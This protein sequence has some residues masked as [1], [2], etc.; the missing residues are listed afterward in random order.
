V[1]N[2][3]AGAHPTRCSTHV[4]SAMAV[5]LQALRVEKSGRSKLWEVRKR[6]IAN[7]ARRRHKAHSNEPTST[8]L[9]NPGASFGR[10]Q[11]WSFAAGRQYMTPP[12]STRPG[13]SARSVYM[14]IIHMNRA[15]YIYM[16]S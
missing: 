6:G 10:S 1:P 4:D 9:P 15:A 7:P 5:I 16:V 13:T 14:Q 2:E 12:A 11:A 3:L 8:T